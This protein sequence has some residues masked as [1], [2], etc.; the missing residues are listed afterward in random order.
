MKKL[1]EQSNIFDL[2]EPQETTSTFTIIETPQEQEEIKV[3]EP[4]IAKVSPPSPTKAL[5]PI[6]KFQSYL[7][8]YK[9]SVLPNLLKKHNIEPAQFVQ[10]VISELKKNVNGFG[11]ECKDNNNAIEEIKKRIK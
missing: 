7:E 1:H 11:K 6:Q 5:S 2:E 4:P 8:G 10:I 3:T 9:E